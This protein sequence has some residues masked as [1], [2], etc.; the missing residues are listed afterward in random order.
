MQEESIL[1]SFLYLPK[2]Q[3]NAPVEFRRKAGHRE[4]DWKKCDFRGGWCW[5]DREGK[6]REVEW[7]QQSSEVEMAWFL[8]G[9]MCPIW[10]KVCWIKVFEE[11]NGRKGLVTW[12]MVNDGKLLIYSRHT[13]DPFWGMLKTP[14][15]K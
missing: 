9:T 8:L 15:E 13:T 7:Y 1:S 5:A 3:H 6:G 4:L 10:I 12:Q 2:N 14:R 11:W